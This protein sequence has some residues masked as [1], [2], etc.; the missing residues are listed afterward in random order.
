MQKVVSKWSKNGREKCTLGP[1]NGW[2]TNQNVVTKWSRPQFGVVLSWSTE[3]RQVEGDCIKKRA[4][5]MQNRWK[6]DQHNDHD[7]NLGSCFREARKIVTPKVIASKSAQKLCKI[8]ENIIKN[9]EK[10]IK[11]REKSC[12]STWVVGFGHT[13][14]RWRKSE[15][16][17]IQIRWKTTKT[18]TSPELVIFG[19]TVCRWTKIERKNEEFNQNFRKMVTKISIQNEQSVT[20]TW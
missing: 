6:N 14:Y 1:R 13:V 16:K 11:K 15:Q 8:N 4:K 7:P 3:N 19:Y 2:K 5:M 17:M 20:V 12:N 18:C 10:S 9:Y